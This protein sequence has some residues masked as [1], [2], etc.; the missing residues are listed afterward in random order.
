MSTPSPVG[1][2]LKGY[3]RISETFISNE[4]RLLEQMG[5]PIHI[6]SMRKPRE[7]FTHDSVREIKARVTYLPS[8][9]LTSLPRFLLP[10]LRVLLR[11]PGRYAKAFRLMCRRFARTRRSA[12]IKH[13]LQA[14]YL[15]DRMQGTGITHLHAHFAHSPTSVA[16]FASI[17]SG[18]PYSFTG[19]AK[20]I[21][22]SNRAQLAEKIDLARFVVTCTGYNKRYLQ[23]LAPAGKPIHAVY[24]GIDLKLFSPSGRHVEARK[25]YS[26]LTVAR[27]VEKKGLPTILRALARLREQGIDFRYTL[28][29]TGDDEAKIR[30]MIRDL[31][32]E[33]VTELTGTLPHEQVVGH[34]HRADLFVLGCRV[35][36]TGDRDG[37]PNVLVE[38]MAMGVPVIGTTIS[39][40]PELITDGETG[41]LVEPDKPEALSRAMLRLLTDTDL[42]SRVIPAARSKVE[43]EFDNTV[44][45]R[46]LG[47]IYRTFGV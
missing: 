33:G 27:F 22:T 40:L 41:L 37:V 39:A 7:A 24:H 6:F 21:Y 45:I 20:D 44:L 9:L 18:V 1:F 23:E 36:A 34:F 35:A 13:L 43:Q 4:I 12:S 28:I 47:E 11:S 3:P 16:L 25:P 5:F 38:S 30:A 31:D 10:N 46:E 32:L 15:V 19:H 14:G 2:V 26:I 29:G 8:T 42:R 17:L